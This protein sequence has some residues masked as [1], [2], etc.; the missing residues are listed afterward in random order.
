MADDTKSKDS[1]SKAQEKA[2][3]DAGVATEAQNDAL[4]HSDADAPANTRDG[5]DGGVPML[6][7]DPSE[8]SGPEDALGEGEKRGDYA[9]RVDGEHFEGQALPDGGEPI[10]D[11][12]GNVVD[13]KPKSR[14]VAQSPRTAEVG[15]AAGLKGG[16]ETA[17]TA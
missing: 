10:L 15:D 6:P 11:D 3:A 9:E 2:K 17:P 7:G 5:L 16:V 4:E 13:Y 8:P 14:L 12:D 1:E